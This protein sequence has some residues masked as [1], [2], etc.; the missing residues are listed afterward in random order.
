MPGGLFF[1]WETFCRQLLTRIVEKSGSE[2]TKIS[3]NC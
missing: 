2:G 3:F 1:P